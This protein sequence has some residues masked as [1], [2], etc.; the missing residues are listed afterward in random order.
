LKFSELTTEQLK[1]NF[2]YWR[3][4]IENDNSMTATEAGSLKL[5]PSFLFEIPTTHTWGFQNRNSKREPYERFLYETILFGDKALLSNQARKH[6]G[7]SVPDSITPNAKL[8]GLDEFVF[9]Y[10]GVHDPYYAHSDF[11]AFG[12]FLAKQ[13]TFECFPFC[14]ATRRN[15]DSPELKLAE[16][17]VEKQFLLPDDARKLADI[18]SLTDPR[19]NCD[20]W[21]Y[22]SAYPYFSRTSWEWKV[23]FHYKGQVK[24]DD[25]IA[26]LWP[27]EKAILTRSSGFKVD[28]RLNRDARRFQSVCKRCQV[29]EYPYDA[30]D[31]E[32]ALIE[33]SSIAA[34][35]FIETGK[36][37]SRIENN[38]EN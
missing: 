13:S 26:I 25:F 8:A 27:T 9:A 36:F 7:R 30:D 10:L 24:I 11:P 15:L 17:T 20:P 14:H 3:R 5:S 38:L 34:R 33:A 1:A 35:K 22:W 28:T 19:H 37:P 32:R 12:V 21:Q 31:P 29:V 16:M 2:D 4:A 6:Q 18:E 23:E